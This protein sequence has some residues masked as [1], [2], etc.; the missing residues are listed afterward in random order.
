MMHGQQNMNG[1]VMIHSKMPTKES[2]E[3][4]SINGSPIRNPSGLQLSHILS[5][6]QIGEQ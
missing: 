3:A 2:S 6:D 4:T 5:L 1:T